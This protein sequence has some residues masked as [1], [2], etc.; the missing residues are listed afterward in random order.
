MAQM[1]LPTEC[2]DCISLLQHAATIIS[3]SA[4]LSE[5]SSSQKQWVILYDEQF[6]TRLLA[7]VASSK[8]YMCALL[9]RNIP[10]LSKSHDV[11]EEL[12]IFVARPQ[13]DPLAAE[14]GLA[15]FQEGKKRQ[16]A[17]PGRLRVHEGTMWGILGQIRDDR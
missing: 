2:D 6:R 7:N 5:S 8:C 3:Q 16:V 10:Q 11:G 9:H 15:R 12:Q 13:K 1:Q 14:I 4:S 17:F